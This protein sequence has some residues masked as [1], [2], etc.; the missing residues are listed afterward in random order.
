MFGIFRRF[1]G[2]D[3]SGQA[4]RIS[5]DFYDAGSNYLNL[6]KSRILESVVTPERRIFPTTASPQDQFQLVVFL[7]SYFS[8]RTDFEL[9]ERGIPQ[10]LRDEIW[11]HLIDA[12]FDD[13]DSGSS[14]TRAFNKNLAVR[15]MELLRGVIIRNGAANTQAIADSLLV[16]L[17]SAKKISGEASKI[18]TQEAIDKTIK[19]GLD[20]L[21]ERYDSYLSYL[22]DMQAIYK[23]EKDT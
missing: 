8:V 16:I 19:A 14:D 7:A 2:S 12:V 1:F 11:S 4:L 6:V 18:A 10:S 21:L 22:D 9:S 13:M 20:M 17:S 23:R 15:Q 5:Q 3:T